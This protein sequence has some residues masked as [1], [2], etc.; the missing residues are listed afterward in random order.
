[1][2]PLD[3]VNG[4]PP[5]SACAHRVFGGLPHVRR[6]RAPCPPF[7]P[8]TRLWQ[9]EGLSVKHGP[10][11]DPCPPKAKVTRSNRVGCANFSLFYSALCAPG[12]K[13][14][15]SLI[16]TSKQ[17]RENRRRVQIAWQLTMSVRSSN[18]NCFHKSYNW[19]WQA[20]ASPVGY[21]AAPKDSHAWAA[22]RCAAGFSES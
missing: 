2:S 22:A 18:N 5:Q 9:F 17:S 11:F 7:Q 10:L 20:A 16:R 1:V 14:Q 21:A 3:G 13:L 4:V 15:F 12:L 8:I 6:G 19:R